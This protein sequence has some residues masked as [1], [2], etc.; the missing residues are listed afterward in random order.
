MQMIEQPKGPLIECKPSRADPRDIHRTVVAFANSV[1][2]ADE[3]VLFIGVAD[4]GVIPE[5]ADTNSMQKTV[6][7]ICEIQCCP[8]IRF[9]IEVLLEG[10]NVIVIIPP[11]E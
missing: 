1:S 6:R 8:A 4:N 7:D 10:Q 5:G 9:R 3:A 2:G 11:S